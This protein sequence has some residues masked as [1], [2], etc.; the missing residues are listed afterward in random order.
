MWEALLTLVVGLKDALV[1]EALDVQKLA[2][3]LAEAVVVLDARVLA[4]EPAGVVVEQVE[5]ESAARQEDSGPAHV[6]MPERRTELEQLA[7][8]QMDMRG[9]PVGAADITRKSSVAS[10]V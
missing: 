5:Q 4:A 2:V 7:N 1:A 8:K 10:L 9:E 6:D 3:G